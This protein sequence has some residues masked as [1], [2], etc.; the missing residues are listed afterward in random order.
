MILNKPEAIKTIKEYEAAITQGVEGDT[1]LRRS[2][3]LPCSKAKI[4]H[5]FYTLIEDAIK[6]DGQISD[7]TREKLTSSY[8]LINYFVDDFTAIKYAKIQNDWHEK[9]YN[10]NKSKR[11]EGAIKQ[12][13]AFT[14]TLG[15]AELASE[16]N[17]YIEEL[18]NTK[19]I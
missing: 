17:E 11:D 15:S 4:K 8:S 1:I 9:K 7:T 18:L 19:A 5:A 3:L 6:T 10:P 2:S 14:H 16:I 12:Y 13:L